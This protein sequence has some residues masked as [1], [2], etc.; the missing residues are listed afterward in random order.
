MAV[1]VR[2]HMDEAEAPGSPVTRR[3]HRC[4]QRGRLSALV[5]EKQARSQFL[6][7]YVIFIDLV[8]NGPYHPFGD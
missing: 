7:K 8:E 5:A 1:L 2:T 3:S 4:D 6:T